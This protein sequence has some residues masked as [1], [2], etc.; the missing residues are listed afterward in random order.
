MQCRNLASAVS[1]RI[2]REIAARAANPCH[3]DI[4]YPFHEM[5][6]EMSSS[7]LPATAGRRSY[8][9]QPALGVGLALCL[10][11]LSAHAGP[12]T[13][14]HLT[15]L[16]EA[17]HAQAPN[18]SIK[19]ASTALDAYEHAR[20]RHLTDK[21]LVTIVDYSPPSN[22][23]RLAVVDVRTGKVL[24][25]TYVAQGK[26]SGLKYATRFS[27][28]PGSLAS[29]IG[30][31]L[32]GH[33]YYGNDGYSLRL[34]GLDPG[35]NTA[36]YRRDIVVHSAWYVSKAFAQKYG[37]MGQSWGCFALSRNVERAVVKLIR[38]ATVLVGYYPN[39]KWLHSSPFLTGPA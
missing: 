10:V 24:I 31:Y 18:I 35:F 21:R 36:A 37:R 9:R 5:T 13:D 23:R 32:T 22:E 25:Y 3:S 34:H 2:R 1:P 15:R 7:R 29:S 17:I 28:E 26:G 19:A 33:T 11:A 38:G 16:A 6:H 39:R 12:V 14:N 30:V 20:L 8:A 4:Q 27:N